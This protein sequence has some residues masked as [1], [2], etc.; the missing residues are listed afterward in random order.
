MSFPGNDTQPWTSLAA[1]MDHLTDTWVVSTPWRPCGADYADG[2]YTGLYRVNLESDRNVRAP[3]RLLLH[4]STTLE[5]ASF[6]T[7]SSV[8][9]AYFDGHLPAFSAL[10]RRPWAEVRRRIMV[11]SSSARLR[12]P[13]FDA[14]VTV[15][16]TFGEV[17]NVWLSRQMV[18][19]TCL[20]DIADGRHLAE[21]GMCLNMRDDLLT[22]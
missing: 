1:T 19:F 20:L 21:M 15:R 2:T 17:R 10:P 5:L 16:L 22:P 7:M 13:V 3:H 6:H 11:T 8:L 14:E 18:F 4:H 9:L 12:R